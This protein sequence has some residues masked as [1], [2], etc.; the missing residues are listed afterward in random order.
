[1]LTS[2]AAIAAESTS[3]GAISSIAAGLLTILPSTDGPPIVLPSRT[4]R[5][6]LPPC[7]FGA[8]ANEFDERVVSHD[9]EEL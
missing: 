4:E 2:L 8:A 1:V 6:T 9:Q 7:A 5:P 3:I